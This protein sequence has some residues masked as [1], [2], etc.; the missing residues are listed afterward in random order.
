MKLPDT[1]DWRRPFFAASFGGWG[2][3]ASVATTCAAFLLQGRETTKLPEPDPE[4]YFVFS[5]TRPMVRLDEAGQRQISWPSI[6]LTIARGEPRDALVLMGPEP[7]L[8]W[9][10]F[11]RN[12]A[13]AWHEKGQGGPV[14][15]LGAFLAGV[16]HKG[17]TMLTGFATVPE[18]RAKLFEPGIQPSGYEGPTGIHSAIAEACQTHAIPVA[19]IWAAV[20]H[21]LAALP[22]PKVCAAVLRAVD[23]V[24][25]LDL[26]LKELEESGRTFEKQVG[27]ALKKS[28][29]T[30]IEPDPEAE[31]E[32]EELPP[33][34]DIVRGVEDFL[35][36]NK[37]S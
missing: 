24:L 2:D 1:A 36:R 3:A 18:L 20:P 21:Y 4:Q 27:Q 12:L 32:P 29:Q 19:S 22:N 31:S 7:Q 25:D 8:R 11:A 10:T 33:G 35:K 16:S 6:S 14:L 15:L 5:D 26:D 37:P 30:A 13:D 17:P 28:G 23:S 9:R 34:E